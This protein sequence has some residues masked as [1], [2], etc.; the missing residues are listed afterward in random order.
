MGQGS[1]RFA[2]ESVEVAELLGA[3]LFEYRLI[4]DT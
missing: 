2:A 3:G 1:L 4:N